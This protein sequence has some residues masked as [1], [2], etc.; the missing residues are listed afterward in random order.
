MIPVSERSVTL[1]LP[2]AA[3]VDIPRAHELIL[4]S[5]HYPRMSYMRHSPDVCQIDVKP[6]AEITIDI[7]DLTYL[8]QSDDPLYCVELGDRETCAE[9]GKNYTQQKYHGSTTL[10]IIAKQNREF[11]GRFWIVLTGK[12]RAFCQWDSLVGLC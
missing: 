8:K 9:K 4:R 7:Y 2:T 12:I 3:E 6:D 11:Y 5:E 10:S 1:S